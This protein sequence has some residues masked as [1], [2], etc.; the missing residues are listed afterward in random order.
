MYILEN[1]SPHSKPVAENESNDE[2]KVLQTWLITKF[3]SNMGVKRFKWISSV[4]ILWNIN[5]SPRML[6]EEVERKT[7]DPVGSLT[8]LIKFADGEAED[9]IKHCIQLTFY[10]GYDAAFP[11]LKGMVVLIPH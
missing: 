7:K 10:I 11:Q 3:W 4:V 5:I 1:I 9:L 2:V 8:D 6:N